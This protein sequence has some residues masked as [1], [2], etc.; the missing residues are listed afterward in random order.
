MFS[1]VSL[2]L[3]I[4][5]SAYWRGV[6]LLGR[7]S[8]SR[9]TSPWEAKNQGIRSIRWRYASYWNAFLSSDTFMF[10]NM[11]IIDAFFFSLKMNSRGVLVLPK[12]QVNSQ[13]LGVQGCARFA[14]IASELTKTWS[15]NATEFWVWIGNYNVKVWKSTEDKLHNIWRS[16][17]F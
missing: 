16:V 10:Q 1:H 14:E 5:G 8:A 11:V 3:S 17:K 13:K 4:G 2:T 6:C 15:S 12:L 7:G 9:Q